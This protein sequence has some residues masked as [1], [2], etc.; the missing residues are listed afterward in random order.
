MKKMMSFFLAVILTVSVLP[1]TVFA[2]E[3]SNDTT[4]IGDL[5][6]ATDAI[7]EIQEELGEDEDAVVETIA[8]DI[9]TLASLALPV[10]NL[11]NVQ[12][13]DG[14]IEYVLDIPTEDLTA[15]VSVEEDNS[16]NVTLDI[17]EGECNDILVVEDDGSMMLNGSEVTVTVEDCEADEGSAELAHGSAR[18]SRTSMKPFVKGKYTNYISKKKVVFDFGSSL[19][20]DITSNAFTTILGYALGAALSGSWVV[21]IVGGIAGVVFSQ[22]KSTAKRYCPTST[23]AGCNLYKFELKS[24]KSCSIDRYY[25]YEGDYYAD[26]SKKNGEKAKS[27]HNYVDT[28]NFY[29]H[30]YFC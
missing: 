17:T 20:K 28:V 6:I 27:F 3:V 19:V 4:Q 25:R 29:E 24:S 15:T 16:G 13:E 9:E 18:Y 11:L 5:E 7:E 10:D 2:E 23:S 21:G 30:N 12:C 8:D 14:E 1:M 22:M 26:Y